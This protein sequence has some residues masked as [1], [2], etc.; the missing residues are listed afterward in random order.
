M[1]CP[2]DDGHV[3]QQT[4]AA[5]VAHRAVVGMVHHQPLDDITAKLDGF[6]IRGGDLHAVRDIQHAA[7]L[8]A[9]D[10]PLQNLD[11]AHPAGAHGAQRRVV[12]EARDHD[13]QPGGGLNHLG[14]GGDFDL[15]LVYGQFRHMHVIAAE[16]R[17]VQ[18]DMGAVKR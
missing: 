7:H 12:A 6:P 15:A 8:D 2:P 4:V 17:A 3:L 18:Y 10:R 5:L 9:L 1:P 13:P 11:G 16:V 14:A